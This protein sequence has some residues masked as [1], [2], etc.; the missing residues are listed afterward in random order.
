[1]KYAKRPDPT[2][3][4]IQERCGFPEKGQKNRLGKTP[5][6]GFGCGVCRLRVALGSR[7]PG[8]P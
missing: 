7:R 4:E 6:H 5:R 1:M 3:E 8:V 2:P